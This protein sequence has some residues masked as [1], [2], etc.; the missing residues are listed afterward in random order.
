MNRKKSDK[1]FHF[2][3]FCLVSGIIKWEEM[4]MEY[5]Y[6]YN[7]HTYGIYTEIESDLLKIE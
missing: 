7:K 3:F 1:T 6:F 4:R 2:G 5:Y